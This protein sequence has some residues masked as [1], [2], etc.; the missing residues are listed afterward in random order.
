VCTGCSPEL[1]ATVAQ[2]DRVLIVDA[3]VATP[4]LRVSEVTP[5]PSGE[6]IQSHTMT[7]AGILGL[8]AV[9]YNRVPSLSVVI[10]VPAVACDFSEVLS[11]LPPGRLKPALTLWGRILRGPDL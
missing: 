1:A 8:A 11:P 10:E 4:V 2:Y 6:R 7:P 5:S 9:L 3:S